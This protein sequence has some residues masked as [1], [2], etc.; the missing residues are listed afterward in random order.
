MFQFIDIATPV[1]ILVSGGED[2][3]AYI[4]NT[5][6]GEILFQCIGHTDSVISCGF[7]PD[8]KMETLIII[9]VYNLLGLIKLDYSNSTADT[10][11]KY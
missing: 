8:G 3:T 5:S 4:W 2:D 7:S 11:H 6:T 10:I 1:N 9:D